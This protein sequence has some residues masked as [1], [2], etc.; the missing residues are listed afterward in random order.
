MR[1]LVIRPAGKGLCKVSL[2]K[3]DDVLTLPFESWALSNGKS[4]IFVNNQLQNFLKPYYM[5]GTFEQ[6]AVYAYE[7][8]ELC[9]AIEV[10]I[11]PSDRQRAETPQGQPAQIVT[12]VQSDRAEAW[13]NVFTTTIFSLLH[14]L[15]IIAKGLT[16]LV[17]IPLAI[18]FLGK[19][20]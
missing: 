12:P 3:A 20:H 8:E 9:K 11:G 6:G 5:F 14:I 17:L 1:F 7:Y 4:I 18:A 15:W 16:V 19:R 13:T 2:H 10:K